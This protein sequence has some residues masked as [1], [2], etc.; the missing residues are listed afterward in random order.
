MSATRWYPTDLLLTVEH[1][2][3]VLAE[4][5]DSELARLLAGAGL[6][7]LGGLFASAEF[8]EGLDELFDGLSQYPW[9]PLVDT[10]DVV[11]FSPL[12]TVVLDDRRPGNTLRGLLL[13]W[14]TGNE[15]VVRGDRQEFWAALTGLLREAGFPLPP[16]RTLA[17]GTDVPGGH[18]VLVPDLLP[19]EDW[20][21][22]ALYAAAGTEG[23]PVLRIRV[24][25][26]GRAGTGGPFAG[27]VLR[28][29]CR[30]GWAGALQHRSYLRGTRLS[31]A[32]GADTV[33]EDGRIAARLR[34]LVERARRTPYYRDLPR[35]DGR[36]DLQRL[37][38]LEKSALEQHSLPAARGLCS[39]D[40]PS[41]EVL[42]SGATTGPPRYIVYSRT[43][44]DNMVR[45]AV[46]LFYALGVRPG[47]RLI[48]SLFGGGLYGG[49][50]TSSSEL[51]RMPVEAYSTAQMITADDVL[52]LTRSFS[53]NVILGQP[54]LLLPVLRDAKAREPGLRIEK[55]LYGGTPMTESDKRWLR[56]ELGTEVV[57]SVLAA[58]DGAQLGYQCG[59]LAGTLHHL[60]DDYNL[61]EVVDEQGRPVP[62]GEPGELLVTSMQKFEGP[63]IR[64]R[65]G[66]LGR[67][68]P[69]ECGCGVRGRVLEY[70]GRSDGQIKVKGRTVLYGEIM[71]E[72]ARFEVSQLQ[73]EIDSRGG[74]ERVTVRTESPGTL[75][76][77]ELRDH[78]KG[79][80][81][82]LGDHHSFDESLDVFEFTVECHPEGGLPR[83]AVSGK[84]KTVIDLRLR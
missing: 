72:L 22:E 63:L 7:A 62:E 43:D 15:V 46:P 9:Q 27:E 13:G 79:C 64:Y 74:R 71:A 69:H 77:D 34:Y 58:N 80:F 45:E 37:P 23:V 38:V 78:L 67:I 51:S 47:D 60:C 81:E 41:G 68:F 17:P 56:E 40:R 8:A 24:D 31:D 14:A 44:W 54:A 6:S 83:N 39:G 11:E 29:D 65:I 36:A 61:I 49:L 19:S 35:I 2:E 5:P 25:A 42:R 32:R 52:M 28:L 33:Q 21:E 66:D 53:A 70:L 73:V 12:G 75:D 20:A 84:I 76:P 59:D 82:V 10:D 3:R 26:A 4:G 55:V 30:S 18:P 1:A 50:I 16:S 48:N 57:A